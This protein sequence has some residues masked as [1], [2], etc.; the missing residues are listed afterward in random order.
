MTAVD[1][2]AAATARTS[3]WAGRAGLVIPAILFAFST[4]LTVGILT[5]QVPEGASAP[6]PA[7]FPTLIAIAGFVVSVLLAFRYIRTPEPAEP[8]TYSEFDEVSDSA[9]AE[10]E[11]AAR[12]KYRF[13][14]DWVC[15][16]WAAGGFLAFSLL[17]VPA[18]WI[19]AGALLFWCV[20]RAMGS[21]KPLL[22]AVI[23][24]MMSSLVYL[25]F[26]VALGLDLPSGVLGGL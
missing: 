18:G 15:V 12:V 22:D 3:W 10:A 23:A 17:L 5:M 8:A 16:A 1:T 21:R 11:A 4:Y 24:L 6:G 19:L 7:F 25:A 9:R 2:A 13:F 14:S 26:G 20:A